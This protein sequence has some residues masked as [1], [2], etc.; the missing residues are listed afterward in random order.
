MDLHDDFFIIESLGSKDLNDG[1]VFYNSIKSISGFNPIYITVSNFVELKNALL[2]FEK[3]NFINLFISA[4]GDEENLV[5]NNEKVNTY[6]LY[7]IQLVLNNRRIFMSSCKGGSYLFAKYFIKKGAYSVIGTP[8]DLEQFVAIAMWPTF[9]VLIDR[10]NDF[11]LN[12]KELDKSL[13]IIVS[14]YK[15]TMHY[16]SF[17]R[18]KNKMKEYVYIPNKPRKRN[19]YNL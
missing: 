19:N 12:F 6:D 16:Y 13:K 7:D 4:H 18:G 14:T 15:I 2:N 8:N 3:S 17:I 9:L 5:L 1:E 10:M 11:V